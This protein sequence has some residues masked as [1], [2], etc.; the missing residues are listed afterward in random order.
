MTPRSIDRVLLSLATR[1]LPVMAREWMAGDLEEEFRRLAS[2]HGLGAARR[3]LVGESFRN[4]ARR[5]SARSSPLESAMASSGPSF[6]R[7]RRFGFVNWLDLKLAARMLVKYP[8]LTIVGGLAMAFAIW[9]GA[10]TFEIVTMLVY[11]KLPLAAAERVVKIQ[12]WDVAA[13]V[14]EERALHDFK[15]WRDSLRSITDLGAWRDSSR[16]LIVAGRDARPVRVAEMTA[17]GF[18]VGEAKPLLGRS[19]V[20]ADE[21]ATAPRVA[22]ISHDVWRLRF[23]SDPGVLGRT[24]Q[25]GNDHVSVVG[26]MGEGF[27]FPISHDLWLPLRA[28]LLDQA[29]RSGPG[30]AIFGLL[31]PGET[32]ETAQA[33][34]T[35]LGRRAALDLPAT[36]QHLEPRVASYAGLPFRA[37]ELGMMFSMYFFLF[38][39]LIL[40]CCNVG[41]LVFARA[42]TRESD[43]VV[44]TALGASRGRIVSQIFAETLVLGGLAAV[45]GLTS[46]HFGLRTWGVDFLEANLGRLPFWFDLRLTPATILFALAFTV[47]G[48]AFAGV[49]PALKITRGMSD[50]LKQT[51]AGAGGLQFGGI[52]TLVIVVQVAVTVAFPA[53]VYWEQFQ[54]RRVRNFDAGFA[55]EQFLAARVDAD[56]PAN[57][58]ATADAASLERR[59]RFATTLD[60][61]RRRVEAEPGVGG[62]TFVD[63]LPTTDHPQVRI[64]LGGD[65]A[66]V[67]PAAA[68][69]AHTNLPLRYATIA[70]IDPSYFTVL[71]SPMLAGRAFSAADLAPGSRAAIVDQGFVDQVLEGRNPIGQQVRFLPDDDADTAP[72]G[73][74]YEVVGVVEELGVTS[75]IQRDRAAGLY[76]PARPERL[77]QIHLMVHVRGSDP[78]QFG[79]RL[80]EIVTSVDPTLRLAELQRANEANSDILWVM[81]LWLRITLVMSAVAL[82]LSL[83][84][85]YAVLSFTVSRRTREIGVRVALGASQRSVIFAIFRRPLIRVAFGIVI[86]AALIF[87]AGLLMQSTEFP[88]ADQKISVTAVAMLIGYAAFMLAVCLLACVVPTRRALRVQPTVALRTD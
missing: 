8:G 80:R 25:L 37:D 61:L 36:H 76:L 67:Q 33:E 47:I 10:V 40:I 75:A 1:T 87:T 83:A 28:T 44:R 73:P 4:L 71:Q 14:P 85:I 54:L 24:V 86:G 51:T 49:M 72:L 62:V 77:D 35:T 43:L 5:T 55:A 59:H 66:A 50:R 29:P 58:G 79:P 11:P 30:I 20:A 38:L 15:L 2:A 3:W 60:E 34:L 52:W 70:G 12:T 18:R 16:N 78:L 81:G 68:T 26:V 7:G 42:A 88:G 19:L 13:N 64:E 23:D 46:A 41:L 45:I 84:G 69:D 82:V 53:M 56:V 57:R 48:A 31:A 32:L 27:A 21:E 6:F 63:S 22:V 74:W 9:V 17:S 65:R 39:L